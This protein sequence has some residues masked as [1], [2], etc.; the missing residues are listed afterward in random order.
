MM[1][2]FFSVAGDP[3]PTGLVACSRDGM[4]PGAHLPQDELDL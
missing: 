4:G 2:I 1:P 3:V